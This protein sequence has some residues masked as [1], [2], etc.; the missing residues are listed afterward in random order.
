MWKSIKTEYQTFQ[1]KIS[2]TDSQNKDLKFDAEIGERVADFADLSSSL[3]DNRKIKSSIDRIGCNIADKDSIKS[4][5]EKLLD[6]IWE[7]IRDERLSLKGGNSEQI[8]L[9][10]MFTDWFY[11]H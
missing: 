11:I 6:S 1:E 4:I 5:D 10:R 3:F 2:S 9:E 8:T 7:W